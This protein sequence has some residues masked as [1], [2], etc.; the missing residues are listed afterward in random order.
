MMG[1]VEKGPEGGGTVEGEVKAEEVSP[2]SGGAEDAGSRDGE[3]WLGGEERESW[4]GDGDDK[5]LEGSEEGAGAA[6]ADGNPE[7]ERAEGGRAGEQ[8]EIP[9]AP[10]DGEDEGAGDGGEEDGE[11]FE[12]DQEAAEAELDDEELGG[13]DAGSEGALEGEADGETGALD[14]RTQGLVGEADARLRET[15]RVGLAGVEAQ[16]SEVAG[17]LSANSELMKGLVERGKAEK[18]PEVG[19]E[20]VKSVDKLSKSVD[21]RISGMVSAVER[22]SEAF[23]GVNDSVDMVKQVGK[24]ISGVVEALSACQADLS[25]Q[26]QLEGGVMRW[27]LL[28][29]VVVGAPALV[30]AGT[31]AGQRW[32]VLPMQ[33]ATGGW[34]DHVW[35]SYGGDVIGCV[36]RG[37]RDGSSFECVLDVRGS[38]EEVRARGSGQ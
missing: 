19:A 23:G 7:S 26:R 33:D 25:R 30:L 34:R 5:E 22:Q 18:R 16:M 12:G 4:S 21:Q 9:F 31:F 36:R 29:A 6:V 15:L 20:V 37:L 3:K 1:A 28:V 14:P 8:V 38:V 17:A 24:A 11:D 13:V 10:D 35:E 2:V 27:A 32:E